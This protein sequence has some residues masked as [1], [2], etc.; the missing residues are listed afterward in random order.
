M[1]GYQANIPRFYAFTALMR[2]ML[3]MPIWIVFF[4]RRGLSLGEIGMLEFVAIVLLAVSE[5][6][7]G[8]V[9]DTWGRKTSLVIGAT[10]QGLALLGLLTGVLSPA[11]LLAYIFWGVSF[12]FISGAADALVYDGLKADG[13]A[14]DFAH[15]VSRGAIVDLAAGGLS[16]LVGGLVATYDMRLCFV[17]TAIASFA[18]AGVALTFHEPPSDDAG[19]DDLAVRPGYR[20]NLVRGVQIATRTPRVRYVLLIGALIYLFVTVLTMTAFQP[21]VAEVGLPLWT[22]GG[23]LLGIRLGGIAGSYVSPHL[24]VRLGRQWLL[25]LAPLAIAG[26]QIVLWLGASRQ[27][28]VLFAAASAVG[29]AVRPV[30]AAVLNDAIPSRQ[31]ATIISL[32]SLV[33]MLGLGAVQLAIL[34]IGERANMA[35]AIGL[36][37]VLMAVVAAP[38]LALLVRVGPDPNQP[39]DVMATKA[40]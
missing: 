27:A 7:T 17:L 3:W 1:M 31:R 30:L 5:V 12:S 20:A 11:F 22:F 26:M 24:A 13:R 4:E 38:L 33:A 25:I 40:A 21:Y 2:S 39:I 8:T 9:A 16:G 14:G 29:A 6:P 23:V 36:S 34:A 35:L 19:S 32:Q 15:V 18:A 37:G 10:L 28:V